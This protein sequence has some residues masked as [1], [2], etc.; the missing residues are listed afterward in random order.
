MT[1]NSSIP[2]QNLSILWLFLPEL[3][4]KFHSEDTSLRNMTHSTSIQNQNS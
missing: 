4:M 3:S 1:H 2:N